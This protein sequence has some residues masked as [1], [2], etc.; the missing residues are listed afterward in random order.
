MC[1]LALCRPPQTGY[2]ESG[3]LGA[4]E[5]QSERGA[6][7]QIAA[8]VRWPAAKVICIGGVD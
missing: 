4:E 3:E 1:W 6:Q 7:N 2:R 8:E 5:K